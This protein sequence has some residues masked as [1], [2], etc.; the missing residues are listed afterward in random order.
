MYRIGHGGLRILNLWNC[1]P[2]SL[3]STTGF[4]LDVEDHPIF[5][6]NAPCIDRG[7]V[8]FILNIFEDGTIGPSVT[9]QYNTISTIFYLSSYSL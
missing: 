1:P 9:P 8:P 3:A 4:T 6:Y 5:R 2:N 7:G